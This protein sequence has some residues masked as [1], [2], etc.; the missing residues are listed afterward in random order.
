[1]MKQAVLRDA[2]DKRK[3]KGERRNEKMDLCYVGVAVRAVIMSMQQ[4]G[5]KER[6]KSFRDSSG[7][8]GCVW[9]G[10]LYRYGIRRRDAGYDDG[11]EGRYV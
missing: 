11:F 9:R 10:V 6:G 1:M 7:S 3:R 8:K 5:G 4:E 2:F